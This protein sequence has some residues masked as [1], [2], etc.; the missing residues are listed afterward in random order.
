MKLICECVCVHVC[1][2]SDVDYSS[3]I[4]SEVTPKLHKSNP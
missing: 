2:C 1:A 3:E 4:I